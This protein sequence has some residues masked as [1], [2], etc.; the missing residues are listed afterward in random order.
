MNL[1]SHY[2]AVLHLFDTFT[3]KLWRKYLMRYSPLLLCCVC[4]NSP[5]SACKAPEK[6]LCCNNVTQFDTHWCYIR[7]YDATSKAITSKMAN[8]VYDVIWQQLM[9]WSC[10]N[11]TLHC[12]LS[13]NVFSKTHYTGFTRIQTLTRMIGC[14]HVALDLP[15]TI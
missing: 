3:S 10:P 15:G 14:V 7:Q 5:L 2:N 12:T 9:T 6:V 8:V 13:D 4:V 11:T 1:N